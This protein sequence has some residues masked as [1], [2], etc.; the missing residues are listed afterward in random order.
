MRIDELVAEKRVAWTCLGDD[1]EW[2]GT[3]LYFELTPTKGGGTDLL[4]TH[5]QWQ[6]VTGTFTTCNTTWGHLMHGLKACAEGKPSEPILQVR[7]RKMKHAGIV[8]GSF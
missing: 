8:G 3:H 6:S 1:A 2:K 4:F 5:A 7:R